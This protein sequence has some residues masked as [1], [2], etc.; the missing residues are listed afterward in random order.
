MKRIA[1]LTRDCAGINTAIR[2]VVRT[3]YHY[4]IDVL[5]V[6]KGYE[7]LINGDFIPLDRRSVSGILNLGGSILKTARS[8]RFK[9]KE[10]QKIAVRN[11]RENS[12]DGL[13]VIGGNGSLTGAHILAEDYGIPTIGVPATIDNDING[14]DLTIGADTAVNVALDAIDK[15]R[16]TALS[17]ER[18]I[19]VEVMGRDS[20]YIA[21]QV[22]LA[23][24]CEEVLLPEREHDIVKMSEEIKAGNA[25]GKVSW[26]VIVA[27]G[28][29][30]ASV[31]AKTI[32]EI[33][34]LETREAVLGHI[35]RGGR[36]TALDRILASRLGSYA[37]DLSRDG[38][39]GL[40]VHLENDLEAAFPLSKA[41]EPKKVDIEAQYRLIK[42]LT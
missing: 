25:M 10:F 18:D 38:K 33:T 13:I 29:A 41:I 37:V 6:V 4:G 17:L 12:I 5:G 27:E 32:T 9:D 20:G 39:T 3:A 34:G 40:C 35:Q 19:V 7:G 14:V 15:I 16:D 23:G 26:I 21:L 2:A 31:I 28:K 36:P 42:L 8:K 1:I 11:I 24:G 22:A 30:R